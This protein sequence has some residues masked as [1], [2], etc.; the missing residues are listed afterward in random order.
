VEPLPE[1]AKPAI[2]VSNLESRRRAVK[3]IESGD[4]L[5]RAQRYHEALQKYKS[6]AEAA[7][8]MAEAYVRQGHALTATA[9]YDLAA[10][11]FKKGLLIGP[12]WADAEFRLDSIYGDA[13]LAKAT[14]LENLARAVLDKP[15]DADLAFVLA[16]FLHYD[17]DA[18]RAARLFQRVL[19]L[20]GK[21]L[22]YVRPFL[23]GG[24]PAPAAGK[25]APKADLPGVDA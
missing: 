23:H 14:H 9:R 4:D 2:R 10:A 20:A 7:P 1:E 22:P 18:E 17:D 19:D 21:D 11:A 15:A 3:F 8:D 12:E 24:G 13:R 6:A 16:M 5:F 25:A